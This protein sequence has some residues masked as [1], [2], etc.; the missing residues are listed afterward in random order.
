MRMAI[1]PFAVKN[2]RQHM[3]NFKLSTVYRTLFNEELEG[4]H[5]SM[6]DIV[7]TIRIYDTLIEKYFPETL[8]D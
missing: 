1:L 8:T 7:G 2:V 3:P 6:A 5:D 4:A